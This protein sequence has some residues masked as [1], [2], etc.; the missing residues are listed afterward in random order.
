M[1]DGIDEGESGRNAILRWSVLMAIVGLVIFV[2]TK[3]LNPDLT[4]L[5]QHVTDGLSRTANRFLRDYE[6][7]TVYFWGPFLGILLAERLLPANRKQQSI[8]AGLL[9]DLVWFVA[10]PIFVVFLI[11]RFRGYLGAVY[12]NHVDFLTIQSLRGLPLWVQVVIVILA[13]D[14]LSWFSHWIKHKV[15]VIW[16]FHSIHHSQKE[17][18]V[19]TDYRVHPVEKIVSAAIRFLPM[20]LLE[21]R[22]GIATGMV[23]WVFTTWHPMIYHANIK[24]NYGLLKYVIVTPQSHRIHHSVLPEHQ[25]KNFGT[26]FSF[27]D[28]IF[29]T[30]YRIY[31]EYPEVG[32]ADKDSPVNESRNILVVL[33]TFGL[34]L[35]YPFRSILSKGV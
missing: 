1:F 14:F 23:W 15:K 33:K 26:I 13:S 25:D 27:W 4:H 29:G 12:V 17:L 32:V 9:G 19:F 18:N 30:Q 31:D 24:A 35:L 6:F 8:P 16:H 3:G 28:Y 22:H 7:S 21:L 34:Q 2:G 20:T 5:R 11:A 10:G